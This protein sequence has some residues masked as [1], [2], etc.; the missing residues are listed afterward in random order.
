MLLLLFVVQF[1]TK[2]SVAK[3]TLISG[4]PGKF[5]L[6]ASTVL[7]QLPQFIPL[8]LV[9]MI[10]RDGVGVIISIFLKF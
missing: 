5:C 10:W 9:G 6:P 4:I 7:A 2:L 3:T 1:I 8:V